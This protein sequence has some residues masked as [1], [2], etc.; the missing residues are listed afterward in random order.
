[1]R[2]SI[3]RD[4]YSFFALAFAITWLLDLPWVLA[5]L[6]HT[7]PPPYALSLTGLGTFGAVRLAK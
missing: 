4:V 6:R 2:S 1:M 7:A 3:A 5:C